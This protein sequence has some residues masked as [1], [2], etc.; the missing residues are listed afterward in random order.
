MSGKYSRNKGA[1]FER[2]VVNFLKSEGMRAN[3]VPLSGAME[4]FKGDVLVQTRVDQP[5][6]HFECKSLANGF[7]F[8]YESLGDNDALCIRADRQEPLIVLKLSKWTEQFK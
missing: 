6:M 1:R 8:V 4:G 3:R 2:E 5:L 7:K